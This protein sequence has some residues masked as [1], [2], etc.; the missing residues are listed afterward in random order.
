MKASRLPT[1][2]RAAG[3]SS[4]PSSPTRQRFGAVNARGAKQG[5]ASRRRPDPAEGSE[6]RVVPVRQRAYPRIRRQ[7]LLHD[8][9]LLSRAPASPAFGARRYRARCQAYPLI[10]QLMG[11]SLPRHAAVKGG[12]HRRVTNKRTNREH[13]IYR[14]R[15]YSGRFLRGGS[16]M[17]ANQR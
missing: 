12:L 2:A 6:A 4:P 10:C 15:R 3:V 11:T 7:A 1:P 17:S 13:L 16:H 5:V 9:E 8:P 14:H